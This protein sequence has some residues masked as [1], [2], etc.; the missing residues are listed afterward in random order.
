[1]GKIGRK[2]EKNNM[3]SRKLRG[4]RSKGKTVHS[5]KGNRGKRTENITRS[6]V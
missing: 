6:L 3:L 5:F 2:S 1:M 4:E